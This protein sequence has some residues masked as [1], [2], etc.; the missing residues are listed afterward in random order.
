MTPAGYT[1]AIWG[2]I[3]AWQALWVIYAWTFTCRPN[4]PRT[5][6]PGVFVGYSIVN[7]LNITWIY[8]WGNEHV[9]AACVILILFNVVFYPTIGALFGYFKVIEEDVGK[10]DNVLTR[11]LPMN[12]L[13]FYCTW[14]TIASLINLTAAVQTT[15]SIS[16]EDMATVSL[17]LLLAVVLVYFILESTVLDNFGFR[18]VFSVYPVVIWALIGVLSAHWGN[19]GEGRNNIYTLVLLLLTVVLF[20]IKF[21]LVGLFIKFRPHSKNY[22][23]V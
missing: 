20:A 13:C 10:V 21:I 19:E 16:N 5:I 4:A 22:A 6:F 9:V 23:N 11:S 17:T 3:Y 8:V 18:Y 12:G 2:V 14:T 1:F 7:A 15:T